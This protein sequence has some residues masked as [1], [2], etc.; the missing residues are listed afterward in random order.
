[1][2]SIYEGSYLTIAASSSSSDG[3]GF[4]ENYES[5]YPYLAWDVFREDS[6]TP[7][8]IKA[9]KIHDARKRFHEE[10][11]STRAWTLQERLLPQ[12][13]L[14][15][16]ADALTWECTID[17]CECG[18]GLFPDPFLADS[19]AFYWPSRSRYKDVLSWTPQTG[20]K[21]YPYMYWY[22]S[23][24]VPYSDRMMT[25][26]SDCLPAISAIA[27]KIQEVT[28]DQ[29]LAGLWKADLARGLAWFH[30]S[31]KQHKSNDVASCFRA[32]SWSWASC[33]GFVSHDDNDDNY[34]SQI[35]VLEVKCTL[36]GANI[37][38][39]V[40]DGFLRVSGK[41]FHA[42]LLDSAIY[43]LD[44]EDIVDNPQP[45]KGVPESLFFPDTPLREA[46]GLDASESAYRTVRRAEAPHD[47]QPDG[48]VGKVVCL[49]VLT[50][51]RP[52][53]GEARCFIVLGGL[54]SPP[55]AY[56]RIGFVEAEEC[57]DHVWF[58]EMKQQ[59]L[60]IF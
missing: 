11:L 3:Q 26:Q 47:L 23:V 5:R 51:Q 60:L 8:G 42:M 9:R 52:P 1:M 49:L 29:Y 59:E 34:Q 21:N 35:E 30:K 6:S 17:C 37:F 24:V 57:Y 38:G 50:K 16:S 45:R 56:E 53:R 58:T 22:S 36:V 4:L 2:G 12:R 31:M 28:G 7:S 44:G 43:I 20:G 48:I 10:P 18:S 40:K 46:D 41:V 33:E 14:T 54:S 25:K 32:P 19:L 15:Y 39:Q 27:L 55:G 13:L